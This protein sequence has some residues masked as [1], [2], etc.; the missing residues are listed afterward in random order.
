MTHDTS[1]NEIERDIEDLHGLGY[2]QKLRRTIG[3]YTSFAVGFAMISITTAIFTVFSDPFTKAGG[4]A[5]WLWVPVTVGIL[6]ITLVYCHLAAR[7]PVTGYAYQWSS[8]LVNRHYGWFTGWTAMLAFTAGAAGIAVAIGTVFGPIIFDDPSRGQI[9]LFASV[10]I[11]A[12]VLINMVGVRAA[13]W[14]NNVGAT[15]E[16]VGTLGLAL[17]T[18]I[19]LAFLDN[20]EG[21]GVLFSTET[22]ADSKVTW[23]TIGLATLLPVYTLIGWEGSADLAEET[24]DP[25]RTAPKAMLRAVLISAI[26]GFAIFAIFSMAIP[27]GIAGTFDRPDSPL[28]YVFREQFGSWVARFVEVIAFTAMV[29]VLLANV[30]VATR[31]IFSLA[32]DKMLPGWQYLSNVNERTRTPLYTIALVGAAA[33]I[34][35]WLSAGI[36]ARVVAIVSVCYYATYLLTLAGTIWADRKGRIP[37]APAGYMDIGRWLRPLA[38]VGIGFG[39]IIIGFL[40]LPDVNHVAG[41]YTLYALAIGV[42]W[43]AVYLRRKIASG[44]AGAAL[45][46]VAA[47]E[48]AE[49]RQ[50]A[51]ESATMPRPEFTT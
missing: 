7:L 14:V 51:A 27:N 30:A 13:T 35:N 12:A 31:L 48:T 21:P 41:E 32:R 44:E 49:E 50:I 18:L 24:R 4:V 22:I 28:L 42:L 43:W 16:L 1:M 45:A 5:I 34:I 2:Q 10:M 23:V 8:R 33:L 19:A 11:V 40:T 36:I 6:A 20:T 3:A 38:Y 29:S 25:R 37:E 39:L 9:Q 47:G 17:V 15:A 46:P 26:G